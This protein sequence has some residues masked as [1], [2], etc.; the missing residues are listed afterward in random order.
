MITRLALRVCQRT[1]YTDTHGR[2][3]GVQY[4]KLYHVA[5]V[6]RE[7][8]VDVFF[9]VHSSDFSLFRHQS[10]RVTGIGITP[11]SARVGHVAETRHMH[12][13][14]SSNFRVGSL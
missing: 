9:G 6:V 1:P 7:V 10:S 12:R 11:L 14:M 13:C 8:N 5:R 3:Q 2:W 4:T